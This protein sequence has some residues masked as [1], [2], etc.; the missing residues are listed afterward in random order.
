[1]SNIRPTYPPKP[2]NPAVSQGNP[3]NV[4]GGPDPKVIRPEYDAKPANA[5]QSKGSVVNIAGSERRPN[6]GRDA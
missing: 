4:G 1:M 2:S 6:V 3:A 5:P